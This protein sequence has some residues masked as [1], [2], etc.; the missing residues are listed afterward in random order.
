[1]SFKKIVATQDDR[2]SPDADDASVRDIARQIDAVLRFDAPDE[3]LGV[4]EQFANV[5]LESELTEAKPGRGRVSNVGKAFI[6][7]PLSFLA[8]RS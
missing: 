7:N 1:M 8:N 6:E 2:S 5:I 4:L 3:L